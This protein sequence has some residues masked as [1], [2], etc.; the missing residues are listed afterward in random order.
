MT[1]SDPP[2]P[3]PG[4][5][6]L[7]TLPALREAEGAGAVVM[8]AIPM[9]GSIGS[10]VL[11]TS[12]A[13]ASPARS[14]LAAGLFCF[15]TIGF[16]A[17]QIDRQRA[18][19]GE[20]LTGSRADYLRELTGVRHRARAA[21]RHQVLTLTRRHPAPAA[22]PTLAEEGRRLWR[23]TSTD[24]DFL[25]VRYGTCRQPLATS[26]VAPPTSSRADPVAVAAQQRF[27]AAHSEL[28]DAPDPIDLRAVRRLDLCG[29]PGRARAL[30]RA[31]V[32]SATAQHHPR[33][34]VVAV[35]TSPPGLADWEWV[36]WLPHALSSSA[37]DGIGP[38]RL[39]S[40]SGTQLLGWLPARFT[41]R[42][43]FD[44]SQR[45]V[46][47]HLLI[48]GD[49]LPAESPLPGEGRRGV[50]VLSINRPVGSIQPG[51]VRVEIGDDGRADS[52]PADLVPAAGAAVSARVDQ[53]DLVTATAFARRLTT[54][55]RGGECSVGRAAVDVLEA[56]G[57]TGTDAGR[58]PQWGPRPSHHQLRVP[59]GVGVDGRP[60][61]IDLKESAQGGMGPH[62]LLVGA[63]GSGKS[64]FLR[65]LVLGLALAHSPDALNLILV[66]FKGGATFAGM[67][68]LPHL[69][70]LITNLE[71]ET[72]LVDRMQDAL[73]GEVLRR[74]EL[75]RAAG[76][77]SQREYAEA[78]QAG[79]GLGPL[80]TLVIIVDEFSELLTTK[81][82]FIDLF[83]T[84]GRVGRSLGI[85]LLL[86][87]QRLDE[88][89][90]RG[91]ESHLS[92]RVGLR[93][94]STAE[95]RAVL[96]V[97]DAYELPAEPGVGF[98]RTDP[99]TLLRF[100][101][102]YVSG[103]VQGSVDTRSPRPRRDIMPF[104]AAPVDA[105]ASD[106]PPPGP[107]R[108]DEGAP[109]VLDVAVAR[110][111]GHGAPAHQVWLPPLDR[112]ET[113]GD[114]MGEVAPRPGVG[115]VAPAHH[116]PG[117]LTVPVAIVDRPREQ[118]RDILHVN[119]GE[120]AGHVAVVGAA[121]SGKST[122]LRTIVCGLALMNTPLTTQVFVMDFGGG[123]FGSL[124]GLPH[125]AGIATRSEPEVVR[126]IVAEVEGVVDRRERYFHDHRIESIADYRARSAGDGFGEV[127]LV[128][129]GW[130]TLR[131]EYDDLEPRLHQLATRGLALGVHLFVAASRWA[132]LRSSLRDVFGTRLELRLGDPLDSEVDRRTAAA[133]PAD[134]PG[135]GITVDGHQFLAVLPRIDARPT[136]ADLGDGVA[137]LVDRVRSSWPGPPG[138]KLR[139]LPARVD[140]A[141]LRAAGPAEP[142]RLLI[143]VEERALAPVGLDLA[144]DPHVLVFGDSGSGKSTFLR[145]VVRE[146]AA[147]HR[148]D[149]AQLV[150]IDYRRALL[151]EVSEDYL[152]EYVTS[153]ASALQVCADLAHHLQAR[154]PQSEVTARQL[155]DR[156][157]WNG[158]DVYVLVD[159]YDLVSTT[160]GSP[161]TPL[162]PLLA[163]ARDIGLHLLLTRRCGGAAR[164]LHEPVITALRD[165]AA[166]ALLLS[167][168][169]EEGPLIGSTRPGP[170]IPG[171]ARLITRTR[172]VE[173][174]QLAWSDRAAS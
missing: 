87:S 173:V 108:L 166:P 10:I 16:V 48:V 148:P 133:V 144:T 33:D 127:F 42:P 23:R 172:G 39:V 30:A 146:L 160:T 4:E 167:G 105:P 119:L 156:S 36:K 6:P 168:S 20:Q 69:S 134:R 135:R 74:Q 35:V 71:Q 47:P 138:P 61:A 106:P 72:A 29:P 44:A 9:L 165:L 86:A 118:R 13:G 163:H 84:I 77:A 83:V 43:P 111:A 93:T 67:A 21:A 12:T 131:S 60:V 85:H 22:L 129:D 76:K 99:Q 169:P 11:V 57:A 66:D 120:A 59:V 52:A 130:S 62:G 143:G 109:S 81:P 154:L 123:T 142:A 34:L 107:T 64:E 121:R 15:A 7:P 24:R 5:L 79:A 55:D 73:T 54:L 149:Q 136:V 132:D 51:A 117:G 155:R 100:S 162:L 159:D 53:C 17:V 157:W 137:D 98:L 103:P 153:S 63:T 116:A 38:R 126:R 70:A 102:A 92:Y 68:D 97:P 101:G 1:I 96:G 89:R 27:L 114:L 94:F 58:A 174:V 124:T 26:L 140:L 31:L 19:R 46:T 50:T 25:H 14:Y 115:L 158:A 75:L 122:L 88:G 91:L 65:T 128:V 82:E 41:D 32:C 18:R 56:I 78:R 3:P 161:L 80:P 95:S 150:V 164:A 49:E 151:G 37:A 8:N 125:L 40:T 2:A 110:M 145:G 104:T 147:H 170:A 113:L 28:V 141:D 112:P 45:P 139:L 171:R 152:L 90:L